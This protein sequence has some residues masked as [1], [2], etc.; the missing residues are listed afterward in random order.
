[1]KIYFFILSE[2]LACKEKI[3]VK[4]GCEKIWQKRKKM[5]TKPI[6]LVVT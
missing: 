5:E 1:M 2:L 3:N 4:K 6:K